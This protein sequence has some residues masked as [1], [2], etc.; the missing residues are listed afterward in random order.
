[1]EHCPMTFVKVK[2]ALSR[3]EHGEQLSVLVPPGEA[4]E[5]IPR[6]AAEAGHRIISTEP[7]DGNF[8]IV[9]ERGQQVP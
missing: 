4:Y 6:S 9:I 1:M 7:E 2:L 8:R 3:L 5:N